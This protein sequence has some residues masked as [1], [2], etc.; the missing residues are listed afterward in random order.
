MTVI[1]ELGFLDGIDHICD[2]FDVFLLVLSNLLD[3]FGI[4][5]DVVPIGQLGFIVNSPVAD[6]HGDRGSALSNG[7]YV[8]GSGGPIGRVLS[9]EETWS[10]R[11]NDISHW[12]P[13]AV[14]GINVQPWGLGTGPAV[15]DTDRP[16]RPRV[17]LSISMMIWN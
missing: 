16:S 8:W 12:V 6:V 15:L 14:N 10:L 7:K 11:C 4:P 17:R 5:A 1:I 2:C 3:T 9:G 13:M